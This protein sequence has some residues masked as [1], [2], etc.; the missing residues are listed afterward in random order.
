MLEL[1][2]EGYFAFKD[3]FGVSF[4]I[5]I[6]ETQPATFGY[7]ARIIDENGQNIDIIFDG[8]GSHSLHVVYGPSLTSISITD[9]DPGIYENWTEL[10]LRCDI[11]DNTLLFS[12][13]DT[14][15]R[16]QDVHLSSRV[17]IFFGRN[18]FNPIQTTDVPRMNLKD[19]RVFLDG[20]CLHHFPLDELTGNEARDI[21]ANKK[22]VV[23]NPG[24]IKPGY[25]YWDLS[26][27][28]SL[29][30]LAAVC[31]QPGSERIFMV[32]DKQLIIYSVLEDTAVNI[33]Y[34]STFEDLLRGS[35]VFYDTVSDRLLCYSL[36]IRN[37]QYFN[38]SESTWEEISDGPNRVERFW[39]HNR[40]YSARD[41]IL[42]IFGGY[43]Q[44]RYTNLIQQ[45]DFRDKQWDTIQP[46][47]EDFYPRMHAAIGSY[48]DTLFIIG[49]FGSKTGDQIINPEHYTDLV[50]FN[51][52]NKG[53]VK[54][55]DFRAP[56]ENIDFAHSMVL[57]EK[58]QSYYVLATTI[59][60][61]DTY[62]QLLKGNLAGPELIRLGTKIPYKFHNEFSYCDLYYSESSQELIAVTSLADWDKNETEITVHKISYPP[63]AADLE[64]DESNS[65]FGRIVLVSLF[66]LFTAAVAFILIGRRKMK[67]TPSTRTTVGGGHERKGEDK[68]PQDEP[69]PDKPK[70]PANSIFFFGGFQVIN[71]HGD[72][73]TKKFTPLLKELFLLIFLHSIKDKGIS[74]PGLTEILWF[75][76]DAK[77]A[78]NNRAVNIAKLKNLLSE[79]E[80]C[81]LS[82]KTSYWQMVFNDS[83][84]YN[85]YWS[86]MKSINRKESL[87]KEDLLQF[88]CIIRKGPLLGNASYEWL[89]EFKLDCSNMIIDHLMNHVDQEEIESDPELM[90]KLADSILIFDMMHEEAV[91][92]KCKALTTLGKHSLAK[93][94]FAKFTKDYFT[95]YDEPFERSFTDMIRY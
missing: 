4:S 57:N 69:L 34:R 61:Y 60:E 91:S 70:E 7:I 23:Q 5:Q 20:K 18:D 59:F 77:T 28:T 63:F 17:K 11:K 35:Q 78:K 51:L 25:V 66:F 2:P 36:K 68:F 53:F 14:S 71:K 81:T 92:I 73:I 41:S 67:E 39:F 85:D 16:L 15:I 50:A 49:G 46:M 44:H 54:R 65:P 80:S 56:L 24:W 29:S 9:N 79:L 38:F 48:A 3:E 93:E 1:N 8:P 62:L 52:K 86:C 6:R 13:A 94:I 84:V 27:D 12:T 47:G 89:D 45:Y 87:S 10:R 19:I 95:L 21:L 22:A 58:D 40:Y 75:S 43:S 26:Y 72:D 76:M 31:Y 55:Y 33:V 88:L 30:G 83:L 32:G 64:S 90:V 74:V 37:V 82:R 42:Y